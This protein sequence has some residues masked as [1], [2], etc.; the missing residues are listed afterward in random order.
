MM[1][2]LEAVTGL[3]WRLSRDSRWYQ[4]DI[5]DVRISFHQQAGMT[6]M[7]FRRSGEFMGARNLSVLGSPSKESIHTLWVKVLIRNF[8]E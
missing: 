7:D 2:D 8:G 4:C 5:E 6:H 3:H 1:G